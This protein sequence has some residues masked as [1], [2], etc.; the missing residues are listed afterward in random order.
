MSD[1]HT[2]GEWMVRKTVDTSGDYPFPTYDI[3]AVH[4]WGPEGIACAYQNP[5]NAVLMSKSPEMLEVLERIVTY[6]ANETRPEAIFKLDCA[7]EII[8]KI[9][10]AGSK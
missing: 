6:Y 5:F 10:K 4:T 7:K 3:I 1:R 8:S 9:R 2:S